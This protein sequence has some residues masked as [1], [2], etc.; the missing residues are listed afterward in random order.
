MSTLPWQNLRW[1][2]TGIALNGAPSSHPTEKHA[3][4]QLADVEFQIAGKPPVAF[5]G[6]QR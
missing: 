3:H 6:L 4:L 2:K 5:F 1:G